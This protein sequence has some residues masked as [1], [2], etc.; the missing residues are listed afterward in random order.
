MRRCYAAAEPRGTRE[1]DTV[2][3]QG[4]HRLTVWWRY[5]GPSARDCVVALLRDESRQGVV[6]A[7]AP[8]TVRWRYYAKS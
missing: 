8:V 5:Y 1:R 6:M 4:L 2:T 3:R 7:P